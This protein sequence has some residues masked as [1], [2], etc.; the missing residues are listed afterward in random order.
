M[1]LRELLLEAITTLG[2]Y[3]MKA[4]FDE[5]LASGI[6]S[7]ATPDWI[8]CDLLEAGLA[9]RRVRSIRYRIG[10]AKFPSIKDVDTYDFAATPVNE[11]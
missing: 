3:G 2:L 7:M 6:K 11:V 1:V 9:A 10:L 8:I 4:T 5:I